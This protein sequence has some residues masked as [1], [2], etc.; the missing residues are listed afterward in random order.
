MSAFL[1]LHKWSM[2]A[3]VISGGNR[4]NI[5]RVPSTLRERKKTA[6]DR[7]QLWW[8]GQA[9][10]NNI[11]TLM[12]LSRHAKW[13]WSGG[14]SK[15]TPVVVG[16]WRAR[17][18]GPSPASS[19]SKHSPRVPYYKGRDSTNNPNSTLSLLL[20]FSTEDSTLYI[21][22]TVCGLRHELNSLK[23]KSELPYHPALSDY[24]TTET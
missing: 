12:S 5:G 22:T 4:T 15:L 18:A 19:M 7:Y 13:I 2:I 17:H 8:P 3:S 20:L 6:Y 9:C 21:Q 1:S 16:S 14:S 11:V 23:A 10:L 24:L